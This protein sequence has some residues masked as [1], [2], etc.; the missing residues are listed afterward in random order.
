MQAGL[1][2]E[3]CLYKEVNLLLSLVKNYMVLTE[4]FYI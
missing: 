4:L 3:E 1:A 2:L